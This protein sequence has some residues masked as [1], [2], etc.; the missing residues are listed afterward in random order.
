V[1]FGRGDREPGGR[2]SFPGA[3]RD[4]RRLV[5]GPKPRER[6]P[7]AS[8]GAEIE[9]LPAQPVLG[10]GRER[11][12]LSAALAAGIFV[13]ILAAGFGAL[14]GR[15]SSP[16]GS[17]VAQPTETRLAE[18]SAAAVVPIVTPAVQ[19][20]PVENGILPTVRLALPGDIYDGTLSIVDW[21]QPGP[22]PTPPLVPTDEPIALRVDQTAELYTTGDQCATTWAI[23]LNDGSNE[24]ELEQYASPES[25][26]EYARQNRFA[27]DLGP[28]RGQRYDLAAMLEFPGITTRTTWPIEVLPFDAPSPELTRGKRRIAVAVG[29][30]GQLSLGS[31]YTEPLNA[32]FED[33]GQAPEPA[34]L[35]VPGPPMILRFPTDWYVQGSDIT[36]GSLKDLYF[37]PDASRACDIAWIEDG[38]SLMIDGPKAT[39]TWTLAIETCA[40]QVLSDVTNQACGTWYA[41][42]VAR[43]SAN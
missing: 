42:V 31:G 18:P 27:L 37:Q 12:G 16:N 20:L 4:D 25:T 19:C 10:R 2:R 21:R 26:P 30:R 33:V 40:I 8:G 11:P 38:V 29:C 3:G 32:C 34:R 39:G 5:D 1:T 17:A 6:G 9:E 15:G 23:S 13:L 22:R 41:T 24:F 28:L 7:A 35:V 36:C 43:S 14:G